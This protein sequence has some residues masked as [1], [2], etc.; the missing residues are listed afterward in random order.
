MR[1]VMALLLVLATTGAAFGNIL[2]NGDFEE[3]ATGWAKW[4]DSGNAGFPVPDPLEDDNCGGVW[5][6]DVG[7]YQTVAIGANQYLVSGQMLHLSTEPL[8]NNRIGLIK[9]EVKDAEGNIWWVQE[10]VID[11]TSPTD[12]WIS[13][14][15]IIDNRTAGAS[16]L[17][18][19]LFMYDQDGPHTGTGVVRYDNISVSVVPEPATMGLLALGGLLLRR[20]FV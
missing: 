15:T 6:S 19:N 18:I 11:S 12:Q 10:I 13:D 20:R 8:G 4:W 14:S 3:E 16:L 9:A 5:W 1:K 7:L 17:T 2:T